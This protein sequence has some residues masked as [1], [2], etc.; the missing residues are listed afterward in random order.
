MV[1]LLTLEITLSL[2]KAFCL[3]NFEKRFLRGWW[4]AAARRTDVGKGRVTQ[5]APMQLWEQ[6][7]S[8][9]VGGEWIGT[10]TIIPEQVLGLGCGRVAQTAIWGFGLN[11]FL[12]CCFWFSLLLQYCWFL[13]LPLSS[14][15]YLLPPGPSLALPTGFLY[16][17]MF[18]YSG[19]FCQCGIVPKA[20]I[21]SSCWRKRDCLL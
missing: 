6:W 15:P 7:R 8:V 11:G 13:F 16:Q 17:A 20:Y 19:S 12:H 4:S 10:Q 1:S 18:G 5:M 2:Q 9:V 3:K 21:F 14:Y